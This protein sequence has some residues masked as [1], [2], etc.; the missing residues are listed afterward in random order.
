MILGDELCSGTESTSALSIFTA[1]VKYLSHKKSSFIFATHFHEIIEYS[2][3][4]EI[5]NLKLL[6]MAVIFDRNLDR[7]IYD[8]KIKDGP[9]DNMYGLEVC[10]SLNLPDDFLD[11]AHNIRIKYSKSSNLIIEK[12]TSQYNR[13]KIKGLC[14][15][16]KINEGTEVHHLMYQKM[17]DDKI[18][19]NNKSI[20]NHK[21]NL[22]N[23]CELC[24]NKIHKENSCFKICKTSN[25]YE[26]IEIK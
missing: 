22:I 9:G 8:R 14:E 17:F 10:K 26:L 11:M 18:D 16:C 25:G 13:S 24:H 4:K 23:I 6:H 12:K 21:A 3:I 7:L 1:G 5:N 19:K 20:K 2:E 15:I